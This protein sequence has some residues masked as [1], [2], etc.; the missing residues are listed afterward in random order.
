MKFSSEPPTAALFFCG[1]IETS[2]LKF[3]SE[4]EN[5]DRDQKFRSGSNF[6]DRWA[7][8]EYSRRIVANPPACH[9]SLSGTSAPKCP[10]SVP[11]SVYRALRARECPKKCPESVPE[12]QIGVLDT[13]G[14][15]EIKVSTSTVAALFSKMAFTGQKNRYG[16][17]GF[18]SFYSISMSTVG[19]DGVRVCL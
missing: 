9:R 2:R 7:L 4:I 13:P 14:T 15:G 8:W 12:C 10:G 16:R 1:E 11:R 17:Y 18:P 3:S 5:F 19:V 6:F